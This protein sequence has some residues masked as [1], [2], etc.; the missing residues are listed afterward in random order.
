MN[1]WL[2]NCLPTRRS[3]LLALTIIPPPVLQMF[4]LPRALPAVV[5]L[6]VRRCMLPGIAA[7]CLSTAPSSSAAVA[8]SL[9]VRRLGTEWVSAIGL[10][11]MPLSIDKR[12]SRE[13]SI[14]VIHAA[15]DAGVTL[16][17]TADSYCLDD[18]DVG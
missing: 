16:I 5:P 9:S 13:Q 10:G 12:P 1:L 18:T 8:P 14:G 4:R 6:A 17:D 3:L 7:R 2:V 15:L 11:A